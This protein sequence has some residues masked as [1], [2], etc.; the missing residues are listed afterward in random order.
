M[1]DECREAT[2]LHMRYHD[3]QSDVILEL[4]KRFLLLEKRVAALERGEHKP[5][6][7]QGHQ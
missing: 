7:L 2:D 1:T 5:K 3:K 4:T 6:H